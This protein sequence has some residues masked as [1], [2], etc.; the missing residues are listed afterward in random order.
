M[1]EIFKVKPEAYQAQLRNLYQEYFGWML[2]ELNRRYGTTFDDA[3]VTRYVEN[4]M[5]MLNEFLPPTGCLFVALDDD[6][7]VGCVSVRQWE[8]DIG[9][10][11]RVYV[12]PPYRGQGIGRKLIDQSLT[13]ARRLGYRQLRLETLPFMQSAHQLYA[14]FGFCE[15]TFYKSKTPDEILPQMRFMEAI[16]DESG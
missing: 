7:L 1:A 6:Y 13:E 11:K 3:D 8:P 15:T 14:S 12:R 16:L 9:E 5:P 10:I 4:E 2:R